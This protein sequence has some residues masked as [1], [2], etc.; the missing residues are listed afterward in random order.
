MSEEEIAA[1][2]HK[3][4][5]EERKRRLRKAFNFFMAHTAHI[6]IVRNDGLEM[7]F[8]PILPYCTCLQ[9]D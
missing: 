6:E 3:L 9:K 8:F 2:K 4:K 5:M 1:R 7:V